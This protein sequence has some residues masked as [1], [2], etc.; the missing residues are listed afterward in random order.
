ETISDEYNTGTWD[1]YNSL[2]PGENEN[3]FGNYK[4]GDPWI[5]DEPTRTYNGIQFTFNKRMSNRWQLLAS[6]VYSQ[7]KGTIDNGFGDDIGWTNTTDPNAWINRDGRTTV[8]PTHMV[9]L[10][11]SYILP[12]DIWFNAYFSYITGET[13]TKRIRTRLDQGRV[14][15]FAEQ[16]GSRRYDARVNL[17]LR[18][19]KTFAIAQKYRIGAFMDIFNVFN[20]DTITSW[21][22][23]WGYD[24]EPR[25]YVP[26]APGPDGHNVLGLVNPRAIRLGA[27]F[28]F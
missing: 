8:D 21:G 24:G 14:T 22:T 4:K 7:T 17:D 10:Q 3:W 13:W 19:E 20:T 16:R 28:Y 26:D 2:N 11:G 12:L 27:R 1:V 23:R 9:K 5:L 25:Q 6:Y 18:L 15:F